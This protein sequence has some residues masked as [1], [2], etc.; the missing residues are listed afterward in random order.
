MKNLA[1]RTL[2]AV[3]GTAALLGTAAYAQEPNS[4]KLSIKVSPNEAYIFVDG[5]GRAPGSR[6]VELP[7]GTHQVLVANYGYAFVQREVTIKAG[8]RTS[9]DVTLD[10]EGDVVFGPKGRIQIEVGHLDAGDNAVLLNGKTPSYFVG[11]VDEFNNELFAH[12]ELIVPPGNHLV[13]V[14]RHGNETWSGVISVAENQ[15][16]IVDISNGKMLT[17][18]W[19]RGKKLGSLQRF[20]AGIA[21]A[22]V[23][24]APVS[25]SISADPSKIECGQSSQLKWNSAETIDADISGMSPV[26]ITGERTVSPKQTTSYELTATGRGGVT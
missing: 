15:R 3:L 11:H 5:Q 7:A 13:T 4:G 16:V 21:S 17:K 22:T 9:L 14:T 19:S 2:L 25:S 10:R 26:P 20:K 6:S 23:A 18:D 1:F 24:I 8:E 12:Q